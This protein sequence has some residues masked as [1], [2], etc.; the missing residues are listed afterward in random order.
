MLMISFGL[1]PGQEGE[2]HARQ[3][4]ANHRIAA[5]DLDML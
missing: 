1:H 2:I 4:A 3:E 5:L